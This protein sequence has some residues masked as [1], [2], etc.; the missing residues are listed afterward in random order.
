MYVCSREN[1]ILNDVIDNDWQLLS[2]ERLWCGWV[3]LVIHLIARGVQHAMAI[4]V[5]LIGSII[6]RCCRGRRGTIAWVVMVLVSIPFLYLCSG[7]SLLCILLALMLK[8]NL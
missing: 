1:G 6:A 7:I 2:S 5:S 4:L 3:P 8:V